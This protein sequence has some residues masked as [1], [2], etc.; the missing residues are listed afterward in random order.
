MLP[1]SLVQAWGTSF[2]SSSS[3]NISSLFMALKSP[4]LLLPLIPQPQNPNFSKKTTNSYPL[5][6]LLLPYKDITSLLDPSANIVVRIAVI[7]R[8]SLP[9]LRSAITARTI[10]PKVLIV[11]I[12]GTEAFEIAQQFGMRKYFFDTCNTRL[13]A[14]ITHF[15]TIDKE[16][17][18]NHINKKQPLQ[19]LG[20]APVRFEDTFEPYCNPNDPMYVVSCEFAYWG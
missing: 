12:F 16:E 18:Y 6:S 15:P 2:P 20:C 5:N 17:E 9:S 11:D 19:L 13:L 3:A 4:S 8:E 10:L 7:M 14:L 1:C